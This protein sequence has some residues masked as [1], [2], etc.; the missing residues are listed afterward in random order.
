M[1]KAARVAYIVS[2]SAAMLA[3]LEGM[4]AENRSREGHGQAHAY[5]EDA[6]FDLPVR[7]G[8]AHNQVVAYLRD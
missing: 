1:D 7:Y 4:K 6:F 5:G 3:E 8:L 2:Q